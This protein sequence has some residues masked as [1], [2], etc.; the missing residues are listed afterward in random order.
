MASGTSYAAPVVS[1]ELARLLKRPD[2]EGARKATES[3]KGQALDLGEPGRDP[4]FGYGV[5]GAAR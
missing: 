2:P 3:L 5:I 1:V 4:V